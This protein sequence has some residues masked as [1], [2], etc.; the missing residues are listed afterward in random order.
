MGSANNMYLMVAT[1]P[2]K[3]YVKTVPSKIG[4]VRLDAEGKTVTGFILESKPDT[5]VY[6]AEVLEIYSDKEDRFLRQMN[7]KLFENG[8]ITEYFSEIPE[9]DTKNMFT[10][11]EV[12]AIASTHNI[13]QLQKRIGEITSPISMKRIL[14]AANEIGRPQ[15]TVQL[16]QRRLEELE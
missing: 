11:D 16:I 12:T 7:R 1:P 3:K 2:V 13:Q 15:K 6:D 10:D 5:F 8:F 4:G 14:A 9:V